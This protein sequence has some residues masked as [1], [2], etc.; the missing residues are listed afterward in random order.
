MAIVVVRAP[1]DRRPPAVPQRSGR[2][3]F[4]SHRD[5]QLVAARPAACRPAQL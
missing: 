3:R 2:G 4:Y 1:G 5:D